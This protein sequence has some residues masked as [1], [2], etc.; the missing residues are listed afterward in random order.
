LLPAIQSNSHAHAVARQLHITFS[1]AQ[2]TNPGAGG[3]C[4]TL[5]R[6]RDGM[7]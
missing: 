7:S 5:R 1:D 4:R 6:G 2:S 3:D